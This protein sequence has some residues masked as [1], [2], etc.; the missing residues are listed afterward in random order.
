MTYRKARWAMAA[1]VRQP[2]I[3]IRVVRCISPW[4]FGLLLTSASGH[5]APISHRSRQWTDGGPTWTDHGSCRLLHLRE[6]SWD[7]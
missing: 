2:M 6:R 5:K 1:L 7:T 3:S 4:V